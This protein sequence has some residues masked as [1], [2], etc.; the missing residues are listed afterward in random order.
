[1]LFSDIGSSAIAQHGAKRLIE[2]CWLLSRCPATEVEILVTR[3]WVVPFVIDAH[4]LISRP[5]PYNEGILGQSGEL[6]H[7]L[8]NAN[9]AIGKELHS[10]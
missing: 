6:C 5:R 9:T 7:S 4:R 3:P 1:M 10:T 8:P 2:G